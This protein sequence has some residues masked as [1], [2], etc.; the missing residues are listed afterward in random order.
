MDITNTTKE[1][2][3]LNRYCDMLHADIMDGHFVRN[4]T[5]SVDFIKSIKPLAKLPIDA[6]LMVTDPGFYIEGLAEAGADYITFH[7]EAVSV[8][9]FRIIKKIKSL[10]CNVGVAICPATPISAM[11]A[12]L[13]SVDI[14]TVMTVDP[15]YAGSPFIPQ[16]TKKVAELS[17][18][19]EQYN[20]SFILQCDG[21]IGIHTYKQLYNAGARAFVMGTTG[22][23]FSGSYD[24]SKNCERMKQ[25]FSQETG[26]LL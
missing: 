15:G 7:A 16:M 3:I 21:A 24:L 5:L 14:V 2:A 23:F 4:I 19:R 13:D 26:A 22:L 25:E 1:L 12:Y 8:N 17:K 6:H 11:E 9:A 18:L 20:Y 10:W